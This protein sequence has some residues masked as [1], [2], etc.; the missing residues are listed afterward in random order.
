MSDKQKR[1]RLILG[2]TEGLDQSES[3]N[4]EEQLIDKTLGS[5]YQQGEEYP[6][7]S[8]PTPSVHRWLH[9]IRELFNEDIVRVLQKDALEELDLKDILTEPEL[10][11][12]LVPDFQLVSTLIALKELIPAQAKGAARQIIAKIIAQFNQNIGFQILESSRGALHRQERK[13]NPSYKEINWPQTLKLNLKNYQEA[14]DGIILERLVG[15]KKKNKAFKDLFLLVDQS[16]SMTDSLLYSGMTA[17]VLAQGLKSVN[18]HL[19][20]FS[21]EIADM[22]DQLEDPV[23]L[24]FGLQLGG[25]TDIQK[26]LQYLESKIDTP[27]QSIAI[28]ISDLYEG[29]SEKRMIERMEGLKSK[30]LK[31]VCLTAITDKKKTSFNKKLASVITNMDI[32]CLACSP[33]LL[34][35]FFNCLF[36]GRDLTNWA[37]ANKL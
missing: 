4:E 30:G 34:P 5:L 17:C 18:I 27:S 14:E 37:K 31:L 15:Y 32:P 36:D 19:I 6:S 16:A 22:S 3:L 28:L 21:T 35:D 8:G 33:N 10:L 24:L 26:S 9:D 23:D 11:E 1:W 7:L 13:K 25:G 2:K 20:L 29:A 12:E